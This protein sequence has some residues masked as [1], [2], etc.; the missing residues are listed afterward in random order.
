MKI[1]INIDIR[2]KYFFQKIFRG[3]S[4]KELWDIGEALYLWL[5]PR[6]KAY[7]GMKRHGVPME[8]TDREW[9]EFLKRSQVALETYLGDNIYKGFKKP[10]KCDYKKIDKE[11]KDL[12]AH[13]DLLWD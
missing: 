13:I 7:R 10:I 4:D 1:R 2:P 8:Y 11:L 3:F 9:E 12:L 5:Y 6:L